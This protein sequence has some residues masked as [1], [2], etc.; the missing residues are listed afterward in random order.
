[1]LIGE[2]ARRSGVSARMLRHYDALGLVRPT[3]R[4]AAGY[5]EYSGEDVRRILQVE[6]MRSLGLS[7]RQVEHALAHPGAAP[8]DLI[9]ELI[10]QAEGRLVREQELLAR[11]RAVQHGRPAEWEDA[12]RLT[13]LLGALT[14]HSPHRRQRAALADGGTPATLAGALLTETELNTAGAMRWALARSGPH[15]HAHLAPGLESLDVEVRR[16]AVRALAALPGETATPLLVRALTDP[17]LTARGQ[18]A[19]ALG[20][21]GDRAA[22]PVLLTLV[23]DGPNDVEAAEAL[24]LLARDGAAQQIVAGLR[25]AAHGAGAGTRRRIAQALAELPPT[26]AA[27]LLEDLARDDDRSVSL[28]AA[29]V[30]ARHERN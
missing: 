29:A 2:V 13:A 28:T 9:G 5:R 14:S 15:A 21:R 8:S 27:E 17:D 4:S 19:L 12:L 6:A 10:E 3:G 11:L 7:L 30:L 23:R 24:G 20:P 26:E 1:M 16:R 18:A 22:I 25:E